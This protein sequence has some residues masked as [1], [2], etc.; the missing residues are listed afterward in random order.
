MA[1]VKTPAGAGA[2]AFVAGGPW[3]IRPRSHLAQAD[4]VVLPPPHRHVAPTLL[5]SNAPHRCA[6]ALS[7][8]LA[9]WSAP[10]GHRSGHAC[11]SACV[12]TSVGSFGGL[13]LLVCRQLLVAWRCSRRA[14]PAGR[15]AARVQPAAHFAGPCDLPQSRGYR[16]T[17]LPPVVWGGS[18]VATP[19]PLQSDAAMSGRSS[20][21]FFAG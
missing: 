16:G 15:V 10:H 17:A 18:I 20:A 12:A 2:D 9:G 11:R 8:V 3:E 13:Y 5:P 21:A 19:T 14:G 1:G 6:R 7:M 4:A